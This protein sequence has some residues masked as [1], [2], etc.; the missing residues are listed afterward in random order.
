[1]EQ[2][3][4]KIE[5]DSLKKQ[6]ESATDVQ[7]KEQLYF[8]LA[9]ILNENGKRKEAHPYYKIANSLDLEKYKSCFQYVSIVGPCP[10]CKKFAGKRFEL[11]SEIANPQ[12]PFKKCPYSTC[13]AFYSPVFY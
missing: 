12:L 3:D 5:A 1:V 4:W 13:I 9:T 7:K 2:N 8:D 10:V 6:I 11:N